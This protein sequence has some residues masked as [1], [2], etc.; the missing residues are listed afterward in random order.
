[1]P[2]DVGKLNRLVIPKK[3]AIRYFPCI[4]ENAEGNALLHG[5]TNDVQLVFYDKFMKSWKFR[6]CYWKSSQSFVF[7][8]GWNW[9]VKE[10]ALKVRDIV[11]FY[12]YDCDETH[13]NI[14]TFGLIDVKYHRRHGC[15][16][17][18]G[19]HSLNEVGLEVEL[20]LNLG[21]S[22]GFTK[23]EHEEELEKETAKKLEGNSSF[24]FYFFGQKIIVLNYSVYK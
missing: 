10:K 9:F 15:R 3:Y 8:R 22:C 1:M 6:Y 17:N 20:P 14:D 11:V 2:S 12:S 4:N 13:E 16:N 21:R 5:G 7:T 18:M 23:A 19:I 24:N